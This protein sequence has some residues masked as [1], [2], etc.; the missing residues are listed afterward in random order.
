GPDNGLLYPAAT[1]DGI[2]KVYRLKTPEDASKTFHGR[3]VFALAA[4]FLEGGASDLVEKEQKDGLDV[5]LEFHK[6]EREGEVVRIDRFGNIITNIP[7]L[8]KGK[9]SLESE[10]VNRDLVMRETYGEGPSDD[11]FLVV[12]SYGTLEIAARD[13]SASEEVSLRVGDLVRLK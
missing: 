3:D 4:G 12:G 11:V 8:N 13:A 7:P 5:P 2:K 10:T 6:K 9:Y 1:D